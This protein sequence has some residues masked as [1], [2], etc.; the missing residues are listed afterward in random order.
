IVTL[1]RRGDVA[2]I[3]P[4]FDLD[5]VLVNAS[6]DVVRIERRRYFT[7]Y[8]FIPAPD[9]SFYD[10][11][12]GTLLE[13]LSGA[14]DA[15]INQMLDA[16]TL[17]NTQGGFLGS[18]I[19]MKGGMKPFTPGE[20]KR[21]DVTGGTL[22]ENIVPLNLPGPSAVLFNLL[23]MLID[24]AKGIT[25]VQDI[26]TGAEA[27]ANTPATT[28]LA[29]IEQGM[30][31]M[32]GIFKRIHRAFGEELR[33]LF[34]LN[35][36]FLD[37]QTYFAL[38][39]DPQMVGRMDYQDRDLDVVPVSDPSMASDAQKLARAEILMAQSGNPLLDPRK[40][41]ERYLEAAGI[42]DY[43]E[44]FKQ[45][46]P[47]PPP[48]VIVAVEKQADDHAKAMA[49]IRAK[50]AASASSLATAA[51]SMVE[52]GLMTDAASLASAAMTAAREFVEGAEPNAASQPTDGQGP[53]QPMVGPPGNQG[54]PGISGPPPVEPD[55]GMGMGP[56]AEA[57]G[58]DGGMAMQPDAG[59]VA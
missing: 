21:I 11:G 30:K 24:A 1:T 16:G 32:T 7:K 8:G 52:M 42:P 28:T 31:V 47:G 38:N 41:T 37:E 23:G 15:S 17:A 34:K 27:P 36:D 20:W 45:E 12:F 39:D 48:E 29:R 44:L 57:G 5:D 56:P 3:M 59:L 49:E 43:A 10:L 35:R 22:R 51:K 19:N 25:S 33:I 13:D 46:P 9:G 18:G 26:M 58:P 2:R 55:G 54:I 14:I 40:I 53:V 50:D 6:G 4:C